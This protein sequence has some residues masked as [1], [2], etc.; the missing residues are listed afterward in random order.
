M[1][2][3]RKHAIACALIG[4]SFAA[5]LLAAPLDAS[6][7]SRHTAQDTGISPSERQAKQLFQA[8]YE[9]WQ[10]EDYTTAED[11]FRRGLEL[12]PYNAAANYYYADC[13]A[14]R[15][16]VIDS[17]TPLRLAVQYGGGTAEGQQAQD[18]AKGLANQFSPNQGIA[19]GCAVPINPPAVAGA[20]ASSRDIADARHRAD[21]FAQAANGFLTCLHDG[22]ANLQAQTGRSLE[23]SRIQQKYQS[24]IDRISQANMEVM[25]ELNQ[26]LADYA[27]AHG[28]SAPVQ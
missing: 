24:Q 13:L 23:G 26:T 11:G 14:R 17:V 4:G 16:D 1:M 10:K 12:D 28:G 27:S 21:I 22:F 5:L 3:R 2:T 18:A 6:P 25:A 7:K 15:G 19:M 20:T 8:A 9:A